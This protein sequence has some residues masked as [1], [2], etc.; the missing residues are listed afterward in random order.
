VRTNT[1]R[2][3][4]ASAMLNWTPDLLK[5]TDALS[6][7]PERYLFIGAQT[8]L[9]NTVP[10]AGAH[11]GVVELAK[12]PFYG[13][14]MVASF[15]TPLQLMAVKVDNEVFRPARS[16]IALDAFLRS[17]G[18]DFLKFLNIRGTV[19]IPLEKGRRPASRI[20]LAVPVGGLK[21]F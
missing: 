7:A 12:S 5:V 18:I 15:V 6:D 20:V 2:L 9:F 8:R 10:Y 16:N 13:S 17:D 14:M 4:D 3:V 21:S 11:M 19:I 1:K